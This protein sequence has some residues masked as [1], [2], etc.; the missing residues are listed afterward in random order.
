VNNLK[1]SLNEVQS[2]KDDEY[3]VALANMMKSGEVFE[4]LTYSGNWNT[5]KYP[6]HVLNSMQYFLSSIKGQNISKSAKISKGA[7]INGD[8]VI[9]DNV[10][11]LDGAIINGPV[12]IGKNSIIANHTLIRDSNIGEDC[13]IGGSEVARSYLGSNVEL[14]RN[15]VGDSILESN[16][17]FGAGAITANFRADEKEIA[18]NVKG[19][20]IASGRKKL[21]S[22]IGSDVK[23][24]VGT[25]LMPGTKI[26]SNSIIGPGLVIKSDIEDNKYIQLK[27]E[28]IEKE[29]NINLKN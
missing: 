2:E 6:W 14:H 21:G 13:I 3:E 29:N 11:I 24:G 12:F 17:S 20:E 15:Y 18:V 27:Q 26:G 5:I 23:I 25:L 7:I 4:L 1:K 16:I 8:V 9:E 22:I 19:V 28:I 10:K